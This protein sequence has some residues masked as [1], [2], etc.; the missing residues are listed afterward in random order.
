M[1]LL[2]KGTDIPNNASLSTPYT[3]NQLFEYGLNLTKNNYDS[4]L[5][6]DTDI[7]YYTNDVLS[8]FLV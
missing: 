2:R 3:N 5:K 6:G 4:S 8:S 7:Q 1:E